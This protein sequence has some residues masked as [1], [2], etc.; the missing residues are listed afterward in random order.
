MP[1]S[2]EISCLVRDDR[3]NP[4][5]RI[6]YIGGFTTGSWLITQQDAIGKIERGEWEFFVTHNGRKMMLVVA[7]SR[8][9]TRYLKREDDG[10]EPKGLLALPEYED[11]SKS[12]WQVDR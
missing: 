10:D 9:G 12:G 5:E 7:Q 3:R 4:Y 1:K 6:A 8:F 2:A 11:P